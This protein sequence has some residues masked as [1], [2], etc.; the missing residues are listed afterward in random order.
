MALLRAN[1][2]QILVI[3]RQ[4]YRGISFDEEPQADSCA[5]PDSDGTLIHC[6]WTVARHAQEKSSPEAS[7]ALLEVSFHANNGNQLQ[8]TV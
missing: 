3:L 8:M 4:A 2:E 6:K 7:K 1:A 5:M